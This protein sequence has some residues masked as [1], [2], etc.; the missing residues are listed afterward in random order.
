MRDS[1]VGRGISQHPCFALEA[2]EPVRIVRER[3]RKHLYCDVAI[4]FRVGERIHSA[5]MPPSP[6][7]V[8]M[9]CMPSSMG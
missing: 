2:G 3:I 4:Q 8:V 9:R 1:R 6:G 5:P 7:L